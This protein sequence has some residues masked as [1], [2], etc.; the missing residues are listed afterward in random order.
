MIHAGL[1]KRRIY[2]SVRISILIYYH[3]HEVEKG[4]RTDVEQSR[5]DFLF[6]AVFD[7]S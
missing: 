4:A 7:S 6:S 2:R 3:W 1:T 5:I